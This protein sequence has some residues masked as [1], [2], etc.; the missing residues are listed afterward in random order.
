MPEQPRPPYPRP[1]LSRP[2]RMHVPPPQ[3]KAIW[4]KAIRSSPRAYPRADPFHPILWT[5]EVA[6]SSASQKP[7]PGNSSRFPRHS[8]QHSP[9]HQPPA[10]H[11]EPAA[12]RAACTHRLHPHQHS[13]HRKRRLYYRPVLCVQLNHQ[14]DVS[15]IHPH[16]PQHLLGLG[17]RGDAVRGENRSHARR[18]AAAPPLWL[19]QYGFWPAAPWPRHQAAAVTGASAY[20]RSGDTGARKDRWPVG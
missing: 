15:R 13:E 4:Q 17:P 10:L 8:P 14:L 9:P 11:K 5:R 6:R 7:Y 16:Q 1:A 12:T 19:W 3:K 2:A 20:R 18:P